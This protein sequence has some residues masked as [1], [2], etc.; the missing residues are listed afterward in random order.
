[1]RQPSDPRLQP[2]L[3]SLELIEGATAD[4]RAAI[5]ILETSIARTRDLLA[6]GLDPLELLASPGTTSRDT[7]IEALN[8]MHSALMVSRG[9]WYHILIDDRGMSFSQVARHT[10]HPRQL[11]KRRYDAVNEKRRNTPTD[12]DAPYPNAAPPNDA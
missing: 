12:S 6:A 5:E 3:K 4:L 8:A 11:I 10:G 7:T 2:F 1:M 9:E